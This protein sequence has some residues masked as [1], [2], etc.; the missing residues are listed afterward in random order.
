MDTAGADNDGSMRFFLC[1]LRKVIIINRTCTLALSLAP[2]NQM[3]LN[4]GIRSG[5]L[6]VVDK[7]FLFLLNNLQA[8]VSV[9]EF[10]SSSRDGSL[11]EPIIG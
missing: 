5:G 6:L 10:C 1:R 4:G 3:A 8:D 7:Y 11:L 9:S 2:V